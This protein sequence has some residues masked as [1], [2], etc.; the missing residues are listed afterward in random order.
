MTI[1]NFKK[2][3]AAQAEKHG[4]KLLA[5][6]ES[7]PTYIVNDHGDAMI[8]HEAAVRDALGGLSK[9]KRLSDDEATTAVANL[10]GLSKSAG[11]VPTPIAKPVAKIPIKPAAPV[12]RQSEPESIDGI[13]ARVNAEFKSRKPKPATDPEN[14]HRIRLSIGLTLRS[15]K[16]RLRIR[17]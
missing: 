6:V 11:V 3:F 16:S 17:I 7:L 1:L 4:D 12:A 13:L 15:P 2:L 5:A 8:T 14:W 10:L 9:V